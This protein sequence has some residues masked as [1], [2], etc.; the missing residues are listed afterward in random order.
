MSYFFKIAQKW[1]RLT[2]SFEATFEE[3]ISFQNRLMDKGYPHNL[4]KKLLSEI[5]SKEILV[6]ET[7]QQGKKINFAFRDNTNPKCLL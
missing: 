2:N 4:K 3:S 6:P 1:I 5:N 7:K